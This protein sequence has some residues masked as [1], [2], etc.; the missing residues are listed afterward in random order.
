MTIQYGRDLL[1]KLSCQAK[2]RLDTT[3]WNQIRGLGICK[4]FRGTRA[5][6]RKQKSSLTRIRSASTEIGQVSTEM[7]TRVSTAASTELGQVSTEM[8]T[9][10]STAFCNTNDNTNDTAVEKNL[11]VTE[12]VP[13]KRKLKMCLLN[14]RSVKNKAPQIMDYILENDL[15]IMALTETWLRPGTIDEAVIGEM[16][17]PGY[18]FFHE[19]RSTGRGG[20]V[21]IIT[22]DTI[23][24]TTETLHSSYHTFECLQIKAI[25]TSMTYRIFTIYRP[26]PSDKNTLTTTD[27][28]EDFGNFLSDVI[29][30]TGKL[31]IAGDFNLH[32]EK[33]DET[34]V[35]K[36]IN[37]L[38]TFGLNQLVTGPTHSS[39]HTLDA[40]ITRNSEMPVHDLL[41]DDPLISDHKAITFSL[42]TQRPSFPRKT[43]E[44]RELKNIDIDR[45][46]QD[47]AENQYLNGAYLANES[48][49]AVCV[50]VYNEAASDLFNKYAPLKTKVITIRPKVPWYTDAV[51][52]AKQ[53]KRKHERKWKATG[54]TVHK[55]IFL[56]SKNRLTK[57]IAESKKDYISQMIA[58]SSNSQ[59]ALFSCVDQ[60]LHR[61]R[62]T[63]LPDDSD[64][65]QL[66]D[67][68]AEFFDGKVK[69]IR[70]ELGASKS[71]PQIP[72]RDDA[73]TPR[74]TSFRPISAD[75]LRKIILKAPTKSCQL[76]PL[77]TSILKTCLDPLLPT[78]L[79]IINTS[80]S[81]STVPTSFK[82][83]VITPLLKKPNLPH[84][85][86]K[87]YRPVSN[88]PFLSKILEKAVSNQM[89]THRATNNLDVPLQSAYR[90]FYSTET[91]LLKV[92]DDILRALDRKDCVFLVLLDLSAAFDTVDH[93]GLLGRLSDSL[94]V[95]DDALKW[96]ESYL[97]ERQQAVTIRGVESDSRPLQYGVP[98]GSV[99]GPELFKDYISPLASLIRSHGVH[100]HGYADD[101]QLYVTFRPGE[102]EDRA[103][104]QLQNCITEIKKWM[105]QNFLKLNDE[106][107]EF[108]V[109]G[110]AN[111]LA[112]VATNSILVGDQIIQKSKHLR[113]LGA[114][115]NDT[116]TM[117]TQITKTS[118]IAGH[119]LFSISK[120]RK[121]LSIDQ[122][123]TIIHSYVT[124][125]LDQNNSLLIGVPS[126]LINRLQSIQNAAAKI[127]L[128][129]RKRDHV[130]G[131]LMELHW[132]P[133]SQRRVFKLL[134][135]VFKTLNGMGPGYFKESL[136][137]KT[138]RYSLRQNQLQV[139]RTN[140]VKYGDR[141]FSVAGPR[142]W[143]ALPSDVRSRPTVNTFKTALKTHLFR[144]SYS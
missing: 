92:Q 57:I 110:S 80:M 52:K 67:N 24:T 6:K 99:L 112:K 50:Q 134:L 39:N 140:S 18:N 40:I 66:A 89:K 21:G 81:S 135:L 31:I 108:M 64:S 12:S 119:N 107:T 120:I 54:L 90:Q 19:P 32:L 3:V 27:F 2:T 61:S 118:Q 46:K 83:A 116:A 43:V 4:P 47:I 113:N 49:P 10:V 37:L 130:T 117:E 104:E 101:T 88:L 114:T 33:T 22:R 129:G 5:G 9:R 30:S 87:N 98:Q 75:E 139:P 115:F 100:W 29:L 25:S 82:K 142:L 132:L 71:V 60:L 26:P 28:L 103:I 70:D 69:K 41:V 97:H 35:K 123:K 76:D 144:A 122:S 68:M 34:D 14:S 109:L 126:L 96:I 138:T 53:E 105:K 73:Q 84:N 141:A 44:Y 78:L 62:S 121:Y 111:N 55:Q 13:R 7:S 58:E 23:K 102:D 131:L 95:T 59:K 63:A 8:S 65:K 16:V 45:L 79:K 125:R 38:T 36:F 133:L 74:L 1:L 124:S 137:T 106:K 143:N 11:V 72:V 128:G 20:G 15:D 127:I 48:D 77:P 85:I 56:D 86:L 91:A 93:T 51:K 94:G 42:N 17:P 136:I